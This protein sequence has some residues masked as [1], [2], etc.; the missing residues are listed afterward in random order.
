MIL[1][2]KHRRKVFLEI[3]IP[4]KQAKFLENTSEGVHP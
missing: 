1:L 2:T 3:D 4:Q